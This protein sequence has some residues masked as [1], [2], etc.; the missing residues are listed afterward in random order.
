MPKLFFPSSKPIFVNRQKIINKFRQVAL[1][2]ADKH[3]N[4]EEIYLFGSYASGNAGLHSDADI[5]IILSSDSEK[6]NLMDRLDEFILD[7]SIGPVP[8]DVLVYT[9]AELEQALKEGNWFLAKAVKGIRLF[10]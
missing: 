5:L 8:A 6:R 10:K 4:I 3:R 1:Q 2:A 9:R 7:F